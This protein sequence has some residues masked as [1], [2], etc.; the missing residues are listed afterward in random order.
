MEDS[1]L[2]ITIKAKD[3]A[4]ATLKQASDN[5]AKA[6]SSIATS[7]QTATSSFKN[8][9]GGVFTA[10]LAYSAF[11]KGLGMVTNF[12]K[13]SIAAADEAAIVQ[14]Q[15][16]A[17][18]KSTGEAAGVT[19]DEAMRL[20]KSFEETTTYSDDAILSAENLLLTFTK[21]N[22]DVFPQATQIVL[23]M[24]TALGQDLKSS[25]T[26]VGKALQ[27][28][29]LGVT[30]LRRVGVNFNE[31]QQKVIKNLVDT[32]RSAEATNLIIKELSNE[33]GGSAAAKAKTFAGQMEQ[34]QN[35]I[36]NTQEVLGGAMEAALL[37][38][39]EAMSKAGTSALNNGDKMKELGYDVFQLTNIL[40]GLGKT[41]LTIGKSIGVGFG[42]ID[43]AITGVVSAV[44]NNIEKTAGEQF[45]LGKITEETYNKIKNF[46][47]ATSDQLVKKADDLQASVDGT[48]DSFLDIGKI[49]SQSKE[50]YDRITTGI[51]NAAKAEADLKSKNKQ[52]EDSTK[53]LTDAQKKHAE[54]VKNLTVE[55]DNLSSGASTS[56]AE[57][58]DTFTNKMKSINDSI[59]STQQNINELVS[60]Y[61]RSQTDNTKSVAE[62][63][64]ESEM[65]VAEL[66][67]Q[68]LTATTGSQKKSLQEQLEAEQLNYDSSKSFIDANSAAIEEARRRAKE[69]DLQ[70]TIED[71]AAKQALDAADYAQ[72]LAQLNKELSDKRAEATA[73]KKLYTE[74]VAAIN[75][76]LD[77]AN[78][79]FKQLSNA[80]LKQTNDE[81][82][83]E[84]KKFQELAQAISQVKSAS[85][86]SISTISTPSLAKHES[87]GFVD[88]PRGTAVPIIAHGGEQIIPAEQVGG[89]G[90][91]VVNL[92]INNPQFR[93]AADV[94]F[95]KGQINIALRDVIRINKLQNI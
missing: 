22:K 70:R 30:A 17:V 4:S 16:Y 35:T 47:D 76:I 43:V 29:V 49:M 52:T 86:T 72:R 7:T 63:I 1:T 26:Q 32:G 80:R 38:S 95:F 23:D 40:I 39:V 5:V 48:A 90:G 89:R 3:D 9:V 51:Q 34:L 73:E 69:T 71:Y 14:A 10:N 8:L 19:A 67:E 59:K 18:L 83:A 33:F 60:S 21:I 88:A 93:D 64:V 53:T 11:Q 77:D 82:N 12:L 25:A 20:S 84:I 94:D 15:L 62:K 65:K 46:S 78:V 75:K 2:N 41:V 91:N 57:L 56:L 55:Y 50:D 87:G 24:S 42:V 66:K 61:A 58:S 27:D 36:N 37:G 6:N 85:K 79:Y 13:G 44:S 68:I 74:K 81:V 54:V 28:P 45:K 92:T 31:D